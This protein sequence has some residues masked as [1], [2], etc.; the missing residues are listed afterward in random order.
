MALKVAF[1]QASF[2]RDIDM[3][4]EIIERIYNYVDC[5]IISLDNSVVDE[6]MKWFEENKDKYKIEI[7][8]YQW[9]DDFAVLR[10]THIRK[11]LEIG[12]D[13]LWI[14]DP[15][16]KY[17]DDLIKD[18]RMLTEKYD[19]QGYNT[20]SIL[21][22]D[23]FGQVENLDKLDLLKECPGGYQETSFY[24]PFL[25][26]KIVYG[27]EYQCTGQER[28]V[29]ETLLTKHSLKNLNLPNR[30]FYVHTKSSLTIWRNAARNMFLS[31][32]GDCVGNKNRLWTELIH[33]CSSVGINTWPQFETFAN[34]QSLVP[35]ITNF[36]LWLK[37][38]LKAP[39]NKEGTET[40]ELAK[41]YLALNPN[42]ITDE[43]KELI[44]NPSE[45]ENEIEIEN[46]VSRMYFEVLKRPPDRQGLNNY[47]QKILDKQMKKSDLA[48]A[49]MTGS[50]EYKDKFGEVLKIIP[51]NQNIAHDEYRPS[52]SPEEQARYDKI[53]KFVDSLYKKILK[54]PEGGDDPGLNHYTKCIMEKIVKPIDLPEIFRNSEEFLDL[55]RGVH[56]TI[57]RPITQ[58]TPIALSGNVMMP[59]AELKSVHMGNKDSHNT[60]A[61]C[62]MCRHN[63]LPFVE[64]SIKTIGQYVDEIHVTSDDLTT[65][66]GT[67]LS[68]IDNKVQIHTVPW[69][70]DFSDY[71]NKT[72][73]YAKTEWIFVTDAD[74]IPEKELAENLK[75]I[76]KSSDRG[77]N[78]DSVSFDVIDQITLNGKIISSG[79]RIKGKILL[80]WNIPNVFWGNLHVWI[81]DSY[82]PFKVTHSEYAYR[83]T[84]E[85]DSILQRSAR[86]VWMGGG[87]DTLKEKNPLW[88]PLQ[89]ISKELGLDTWKK[90]DDYLQK[91]Q[92]DIRILK[93][94]KDMC[95]LSW[96][97]NELHDLL[98]Y[99]LWLHPDE[100]ER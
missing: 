73:S 97:D 17:N 95:G 42:E 55:R 71:K 2:S 52:L 30:Y 28:K 99:Y 88:R 40:R 81:K 79:K 23:Q 74:E 37:A 50:N 36:R 53:R 47:V 80:F 43:I 16:E 32:G 4:K 51:K 14:S 70:D 68:S 48:E 91:G 29:H 61:Y 27:M 83:H 87:G 33:W 15:D 5:I 66:D 21:C 64:E 24:K 49:L 93:I 76:I 86:N 35:D 89:D 65:E 58:I 90:F 22:K 26:Y 60:V 75:G 63:E 8:K 9:A 31:G 45:V 84:K 69:T 11:A 77:N 7:V 41:W 25:A 72:Y 12:I 92:I 59:K 34:N 20:F 6:Q 57:I 1:A 62:V 38:A 46:F 44:N 98:N 94:F 54:R 10:N 18:I 13:W 67:K 96:K 3:T 19:S 82:Y 78:Y 39:A 85:R 56:Q 100:E